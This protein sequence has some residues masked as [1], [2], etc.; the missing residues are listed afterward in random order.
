MSENK[1]LWHNRKVEYIKLAE[2]QA[3]VLFGR[4]IET[5][6][7]GWKEKVWHLQTFEQM[8]YI[9]NAARFFYGSRPGSEHI[10]EL[11]DGAGFIFQAK[12]AC[13]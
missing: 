2:M 8:Q 13:D 12:Y 6:R 4:G 5:G 11:P 1:K 10:T 3:S 7:R 9:V